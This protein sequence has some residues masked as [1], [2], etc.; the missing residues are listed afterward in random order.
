VS[1]SHRRQWVGLEGAPVTSAFSIH[2]PV[3]GRRVGL[4]LSVINDEIGYYNILTINTL[5]AYRMAFDA[6]SL[7]IG[8]QGSYRRYGT[9]QNAVRTTQGNDPVSENPGGS[10]SVFNVGMGAWFEAK[11]YF[12]GAS[13]PR[14]LKKSLN[15]DEPGTPTDA[16]GE[17]PHAYL[18][19]GAVF[20]LG[21]NLKIKPAVMARYV[22]HAPMSFDVHASLGL[23][24]NLWIGA[25]YRWGTHPQSPDLNSAV[26]AMVQYHFDRFKVGAAYD[27][28][29]GKIQNNQ[30]GTF[31]LMVSYC[32]E[33]ERTGVRNPR[34]F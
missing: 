9:D 23:P 31:E 30:A 8:L 27:Y 33:N 24:A 14:L 18:M 4:G 32:R 1:L 19:T 6:R 3:F 34:F 26:S 7:S 22:N 29:L 13:V 12:I 21:N 2:S 17:R 15:P 28:A 25:T 20:P 11:R 16:N 10:F 5:Y